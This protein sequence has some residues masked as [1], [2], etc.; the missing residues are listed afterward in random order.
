MGRPGDRHSSAGRADKLASS[1]CT[2]AQPG[3]PGHFPCAATA[4]TPAARLPATQA[5]RVELL[6]VAHG[7]PHVELDDVRLLLV[8]GGVA[9]ELDDLDRLRCCMRGYEGWVE[10]AYSAAAGDRGGCSCT[11]IHSYRNINENETFRNGY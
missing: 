3:A 7:E 1:K 11:E 4:A 9:G 5:S 6:V 10:A 8:T 2:H